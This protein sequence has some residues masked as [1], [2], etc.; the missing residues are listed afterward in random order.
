MALSP[1][2][3]C[4]QADL[5]CRARACSNRRITSG[6]GGS[7]YCRYH[8]CTVCLKLRTCFKRGHGEEK[9]CHHPDGC[10]HGDCKEPRDRKNGS[11]SPYCSKHGCTVAGCDQPRHG[12]G[13]CCRRHTCRGKGC[14]NCIVPR[15]NGGR[16]S[17]SSSSSSSSSSPHHY[18][19]GHRVCDAPGCASFALLDAACHRA[20]RF[21]HRHY[22][23]AAAACAEQRVDG[24][25]AD[26]CREHTCALYPACGLP[27]AAAAAHG[28]FCAEHECSE[29]GCVRQRY[30][31]GGGG[32]GGDGG[33]PWCAD[34]MCMAAL[35][36]Q[37][38]CDARREG[39]A[40]NPLHCADHEPCE[41][42]GCG[43]FRAVRGRGSRLSRCEDHLVGKAKCAVPHC[44]LGVEGGITA[45]ASSMLLPPPPAFCDAHRCAEVGCASPR[46]AAVASSL[47][48]TDINVAAGKVAGTMSVSVKM[49]HA[50]SGMGL[51]MMT[52][53][54]TMRTQ[55]A[56]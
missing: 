33:G 40:A 9:I 20:A 10:I 42:S 34:H 27:R 45:F 15:D 32:G 23:G 55:V 17:P 13:R 4:F 52:M 16:L 1:W 11:S 35:T 21:C 39:S 46:A 14:V 30:E 28:L 8:V 7:P 37:E 2:Q 56:P 18:C 26:A 19:P 36:R 41:V 38:D 43:Q 6:A 48:V 25:D 12:S 51:T 29:P 49:D 50:A 22:C 53:T 54:T 44:A 5:K 31:S 47:G 3:L 24:P